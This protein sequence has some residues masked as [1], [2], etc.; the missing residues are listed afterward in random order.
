MKVFVK[1]LRK[2]LEGWDR[3]NDYKQKRVILSTFRNNL[4]NHNKKGKSIKQDHNKM[5]KIW[6]CFTNEIPLDC[7]C[8]EIRVRLKKWVKECRKK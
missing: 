4:R 3:H 1:I 7:C 5:H 6:V 8:Q 2:Q